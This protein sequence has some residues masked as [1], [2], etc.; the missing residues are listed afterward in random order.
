MGN[1]TDG[2]FITS[3]R[4][5]GKQL[6]MEKIFISLTEQDSVIPPEEVEESMLKDFP[7][8]VN[9]EWFYENGAYETIFYLNNK[10]HIAKFDR[11]AKLIDYRINLPLSELPALIR[12]AVD[13]GKE[14][15]NLV[16]IHVDEAVFYELILR[17]KDLVRFVALFNQKGENLGVKAL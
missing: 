8:A 9:I 6:D 2:Y 11:S 12:K 4:L 3:C 14:I 1:Q 16:E 15:M 17:N 13:P 5:Y 10:E 7:D